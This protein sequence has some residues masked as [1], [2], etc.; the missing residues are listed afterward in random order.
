M[1][2]FHV[3]STEM[4][5]TEEVINEQCSVEIL[6]TEDDIDEQSSSLQH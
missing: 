2:N 5:S 1:N 3:F 6:S 4:F